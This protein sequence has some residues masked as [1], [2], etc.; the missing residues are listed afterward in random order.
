M[1]DDVPLAYLE[2]ECGARRHTCR[3]CGKPLRE[4][5]YVRIEGHT[6]EILLYCSPHCLEADWK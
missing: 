4:K 1:L 6:G 5:A 2:G 3:Y